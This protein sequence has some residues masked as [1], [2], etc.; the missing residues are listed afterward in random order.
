MADPICKHNQK[1]FCKFA[2]RCRNR[3][4]DEICG[5]S[6]CDGENC[7]LRH[8][9]ECRYFNLNGSCKFGE[10]CAYLHKDSDNI[11][12]I[13]KLEEKLAYT[14]TKIEE[15]EKV[16][17]EIQLKLGPTEVN[18]ISRGSCDEHIDTE[19]EVIEVGFPCNLCDFKS[20]WKNGLIVHT[21]RK[22]KKIEQLDGNIETDENDEDIAYQNTE[23]YWCKGLLGRSFQSYI[24]ANEILEESNLDKEAKEAEKAAV[25]DARK[26]AFGDDHKYYPPWR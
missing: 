3:H 6:N 21:S 10:R 18:N 2:D 16:V 5:D 13:K 8:Q 14:E 24:D 17:K 1:G 11:A 23:S 26:E 7:V 19:P 9:V 15:L 20:S 4:V 25:L 22:H 12:K